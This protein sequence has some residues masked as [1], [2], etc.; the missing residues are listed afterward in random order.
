MFRGGNLLPF[1]HIITKVTIIHFHF[2]ISSLVH[3]S[4]V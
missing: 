3:E 4:L 1:C 2:S